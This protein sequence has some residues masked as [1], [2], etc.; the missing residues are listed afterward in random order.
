M[1]VLIRTTAVLIRMDGRVLCIKRLLKEPV[2]WS[3]PGGMVDE[4][5]TPLFSARRK[6]R[7]QVGIDCRC[8]ELYPNRTY[9]LKR[10]DAEVHATFF[11]L[12]PIRG[13]LRRIKS[14]R[15]DI[16]MREVPIENLITHRPFIRDH[17]MFLEDMELWR[18]QP[19][20][21]AA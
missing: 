21:A 1:T 14:A 10:A 16:V 2:H 12:R 9:L 4:A 20:V 8:R 7:D 15:A 17:R 18:K 6:L 19:S 11:E 13:R 5:E 3:L